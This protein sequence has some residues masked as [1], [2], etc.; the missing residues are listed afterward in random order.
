MPPT[1]ETWGIHYDV[2]R[3]W[4]KGK[5]DTSFPNGENYNQAY[6]RM[7]DGLKVVVEEMDGQNV[8]ISGHG[9]IFF[10]VMGE[11]CPKVNIQELIQEINHNCSITEINIK[12]EN[13]KLIGDLVCWADISHLHGEAADLVLGFPEEN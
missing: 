2:I 5:L 11:L 10:T 8:I 13:G 6:Q 4:L 1:R 7:L 3:D 9:G 12:K